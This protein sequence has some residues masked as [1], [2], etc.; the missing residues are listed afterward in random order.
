[1][2]DNTVVFSGNTMP[3]TCPVIR[4]GMILF[5][6]Q[7]DLSSVQADEL[8]TE[9]AFSDIEFLSSSGDVKKMTGYSIFQIIIRHSKMP[10][11]DMELRKKGEK[12]GIEIQKQC[13]CA[14]FGSN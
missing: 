11:I 2:F 1:M 7:A 14:D 3:C 13:L 9:N 5:S 8:F 4:N 12:N 6:I 10:F